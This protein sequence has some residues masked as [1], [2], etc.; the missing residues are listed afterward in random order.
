MQFTSQPKL[1]KRSLKLNYRAINISL[2]TSNEIWAQPMI[3]TVHRHHTH[4]RKHSGQ[5][6]INYLNA[7]INLFGY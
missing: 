6:Q 2:H 5:A 4:S 1:S 3:P 7:F